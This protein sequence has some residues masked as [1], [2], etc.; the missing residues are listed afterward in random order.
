MTDYSLELRVVLPEQVPVDVIPA[1]PGPQGETGPTGPAGADGTGLEIDAIDTLSNRTLY[2]SEAEGFTFLASDTGD[3]YRRQGASAGS[4]SAGVSLQ[5]PEGPEGPQG[6]PGEGVPVGGTTGQV[7]AK[8][9]GTDY[10]TEWVAPPSGAGGWVLLDEETLGSAAS[11]VVF[12]GLDTSYKEFRLVV[13]GTMAG[14]GNTLLRLNADTGNNYRR[15][16]ELLSSESTTITVTTDGSATSSVS[17]TTNVGDG[18]Q[19][20]G[21]VLVS[22]RLA[23]RPAAVRSE[24]WYTTTG[25]IVNTERVLGGWSNTAD[26]VST[27]TILRSSNNFAA[28][29]VF[30][31]YGRA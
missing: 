30:Q 11:S 21:E 14:S 18:Q 7:L 19:F 8:A 4:W 3:F 5:G 22:K 9:S 20:A 15:T 23:G 16:R 13:R 31:L 1:I 29:S 24:V 6:D 10:D 25:T 17:V 28:G 27:V 26:L 2:D 12:S